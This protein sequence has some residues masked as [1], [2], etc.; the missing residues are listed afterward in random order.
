MIT[1]HSVAA[2]S[3]TPPIM[4]DTMAAMPARGRAM[5]LLNAKVADIDDYY[6][7][8][9]PGEP[10]YGVDDLHTHPAQ[11]RTFRLGVRVTF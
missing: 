6:T 5:A 3:V 8:R 2:D 9:L 11:P 1:S 7:S 10:A 4:P